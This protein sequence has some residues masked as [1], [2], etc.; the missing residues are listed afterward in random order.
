MFIG[1]V[2]IINIATCPSVSKDTT[3]YLQLLI[4]EHHVQFCELYDSEAFIPKMHFLIHS[5]SQLLR[6]GPL[7]NSWTMRYEAKL[8]AIKRAAHISNFKNVYQT[9]AKRHQHLLCYKN[10]L[11]SS[12]VELGPS[13]C[14]SLLEEE[15]T[16]VRAYLYPLQH[17]SLISH[18]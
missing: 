9:V 2:I 6:F 12:E 3:A 11:L 15:C 14:P 17:T 10:K 18:P 7:I 13:K 1:N 8:R 16:E 5:P 4:E